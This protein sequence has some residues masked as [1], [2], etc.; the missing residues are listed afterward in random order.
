MNRRRFLLAATGGASLAA[1]GT[2]CYGF[3]EAGWIDVRETT[4]PLPNLPRE[5]H[6]TRIAFLTD[7]HHGP[8]TDQSYLQSI[9]RTTNLSQPDLVL[10]GGDYS[11]RDAKYIGPCFEVLAELRAPMGVY[12]VLGNHDYWHGLRQTCEGF[13]SARIRE[14]TNDQVWFERGGRRVCVAGVDDFWE[15][16]PDLNT[17]LKN[18]SRG[19]ACL[20][21]SHN[22]DYCE[23][24]VDR[25]VGLVLS[26]HTHGGQIVLPGQVTPFVPSQYGTKYLRGIVQAPETTVFVSRG[27][28]TSLVPARFGSRPELNLITI[29]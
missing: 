27:L 1:L 15:G 25:R 24:H 5:F 21:L 10:L 14:L 17:A 29:V 16:A 8:Y 11:L 19:D 7:I 6:G 20:L 26:G 2:V 13:R 22:P 3:F 23:R 28:G 9:V 4:L 12:G 18:V